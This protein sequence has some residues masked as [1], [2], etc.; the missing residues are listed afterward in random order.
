MTGFIKYLDDNCN[1]NSNPFLVNAVKASLSKSS[2]RSSR[3]DSE[4]ARLLHKEDTHSGPLHNFDHIASAFEKYD[5]A[6]LSKDLKPL[7]NRNDRH[8]RQQSL[9]DHIRRGELFLTTDGELKKPTVVEASSP[10]RRD[11][12]ERLTDHRF[13]TGIH[14]ERFDENGRGRGMAG[15]ENLYLFDGNTESFSRV[16]EVYSSV[17]PRVRPPVV[18]KAPI[19]KF[20][21]QVPTPKLM[22]LYRNGDKHHDGKPFYLRPFIKSMQVLH[23]EIGKELTLIAGPVRKI[24][25]QNLRHV[26]RL[27]DIVDGAKYL[28]TSGES[29]APADKLEK[30]MSEWVI[31][32]MF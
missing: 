11:V 3:R 21:L 6:E 10:K 18:T 23:V 30:F 2:T 14:R 13:Y 32:K 15:R 25:D 17:L 4:N 5:L 16:H 27:E 8:L 7:L 9:R 29:P 1:Y 22:W 28:C 20:G 31:Q 12:F 26:T 19:R 24:Y